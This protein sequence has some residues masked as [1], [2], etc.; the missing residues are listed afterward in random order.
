MHY[1]TTKRGRLGAVIQGSLIDI[2]AASKALGLAVPCLDI[3]SLLDLSLI[4]I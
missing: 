3:W 2:D 4:H 1:V